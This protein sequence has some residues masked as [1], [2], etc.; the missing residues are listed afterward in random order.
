MTIPETNLN[1]DSAVET[2]LKN[3]TKNGILD[4]TVSIE[5]KLSLALDNF[6]LICDN[7]AHII[8]L[9]PDGPT[10]QFLLNS[11]LKLKRD[12]QQIRKDNPELKKFK[13]KGKPKT[14]AEPVKVQKF[15]EG[16][17]TIISAYK[18]LG[19]GKGKELKPLAK[20][21]KVEPKAF[22]LADL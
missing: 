10:G 19:S 21:K 9:E 11:L 22:S 13:Q 3:Q 16:K 18:S 14:Q 2:I 4:S 17:K 7:G 20:P 5:I 1:F 8:H 12:A 15:P 6:T